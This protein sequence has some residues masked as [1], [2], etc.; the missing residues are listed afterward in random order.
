MNTQNEIDFL[1]F[2][3]ITRYNKLQWF[4]SHVMCLASCYFA[5][6]MDYVISGSLSIFLDD[7]IDN[8]VCC[9][10]IDHINT[11][12]MVKIIELFGLTMNIEHIPTYNNV[13][14]LFY[15][16]FYVVGFNKWYTTLEILFYW[17]R[18]YTVLKLLH[19]NSKCILKMNGN[20]CV[21]GKL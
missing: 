9:I 11:F 7:F 4:E 20:M 19:R 21:C 6:K 5:G 8:S 17:R 18:A 13:I 10:P 12:A 2:Y 14:M 3:R 1:V 15:G 16:K